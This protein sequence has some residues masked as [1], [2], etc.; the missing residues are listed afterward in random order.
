[1]F[2][3]D[4]KI[5]VLLISGLLRSN[6]KRQYYKPWMWCLHR[7]DCSPSKSVII[8]GGSRACKC[9]SSDSKTTARCCR[10][11]IKITWRGTVCKT[12]SSHNLL[13]DAWT[14]A[15]FANW[16]HVRKALEQICTLLALTNPARS[17]LPSLV[18]EQRGKWSFFLETTKSLK[19]ST[20]FSVFPPLSPRSSSPRNYKFWIRYIRMALPNVRN[21]K[22][23]YLK[24]ASASLLL[25]HSFPCFTLPFSSQYFQAALKLSQTSVDSS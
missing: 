9:M 16:H 21:T 19:I 20:P 22:S 2:L 6:W 13:T 11:I 23:L 14:Q 25:F 8:S 7:V 5:S 18:P 24:A 17:I 3:R 4:F 15:Q 10:L 12:T 1:M